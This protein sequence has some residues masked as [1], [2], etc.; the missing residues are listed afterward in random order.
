[1][2]HV[3]IVAGLPGSGKSTLASRLAEALKLPLICKDTIKEALFD[4][5]G[6]RNREEK[7]ILNTASLRILFYAAKQ[8]LTGGSGVIL[9]NN[10]ENDAY[11]LFEDLFRCVHAHPLTVF[12]GGE[13]MAIYK[14]YIARD[15]DAFRHRGHVLSTEYPERVDIGHI[16]EPISFELF[17]QRFRERGMMDFRVGN[18][19]V[20]V[21]ATDFSKID[22]DD[23]L[24]QVRKYLG[25]AE[26][27]DAKATR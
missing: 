2:L 9:E 8:I 1:M 15:Q 7:T 14:R 24:E 23:I 11:P 17:C 3:V 27:G 5:V 12:V 10:F 22:F 18:D 16:P 21:D 26:S 4:T 19:V 6:F 20:Y 25:S 13:T